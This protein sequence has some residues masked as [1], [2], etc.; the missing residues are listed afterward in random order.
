[1]CQSSRVFLQARQKPAEIS[2][3]Q[4]KG[5]GHSEQHSQTAHTFTS[6]KTHGVQ[7]RQA[8]QLHC[9]RT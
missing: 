2:L 5:E 1:M 6:H 7:H 4:A 9:L 8:K 3:H